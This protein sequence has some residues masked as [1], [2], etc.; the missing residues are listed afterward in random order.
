MNCHE[1]NVPTEASLGE[2]MGHPH[3]PPELHHAPSSHC[4][5]APT[6]DAS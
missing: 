1:L 4:Q 2:E 3:P 6:C 5:P